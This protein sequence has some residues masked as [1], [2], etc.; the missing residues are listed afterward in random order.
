MRTLLFTFLFAA[1]A[2]THAAD[3]WW[4]IRLSGKPLGYQHVTTETLPNGNIRTTVTLLEVYPELKMS[5]AVSEIVPG[6]KPSQAKL[7][8]RVAGGWKWLSE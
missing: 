4:E 6:P 5:H 8:A 2:T 1:L 3:H 7:D